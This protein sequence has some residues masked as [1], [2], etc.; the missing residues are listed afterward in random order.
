MAVVQEPVENGGGED[1][2]AGQEL[3]PIPDAFVGGDE[4]AAAAVA[5]RN[6]AEEEAGLLPGG[7]F[8]F[9]D[10][11][12]ED[13]KRPVPLSPKMAAILQAHLKRQEELRA[14]DQDLD[15]VFGDLSGQ[16]A[17]SRNILRSHT[18]PIAKR[19]GIKRSVTLYSLRYSFM[20]HSTN[21]SRA[22]KLT[23]RVMGHKTV[24]FS[25]DVYN[26]PDDEALRESTLHMDEFLPDTD[27]DSAGEEA[28]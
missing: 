24:T 23:S 21:M 20:T 11:K 5:V 10:P 25:E 26:D 12:T 18:K 13:S 9:D 6:H 15:L 28:A 2:V 8:T 17:D 22:P 4:D 3:G 7:V 1:L 14:Y 16:P 27:V 19:A